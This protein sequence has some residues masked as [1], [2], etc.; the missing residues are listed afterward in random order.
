MNK[1]PYDFQAPYSRQT[2]ITGA[3]PCPVI[4][5][6]SGA[7]VA[8]AYDDKAATLFAAAPEL[9]ELLEYIA[10]HA[11]MASCNH[12]E[13]FMSTLEHRTASL[14]EISRRTKLAIAKAKGE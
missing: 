12:G 5:D 7:V 6:K 10:G 2:D 3:L 9:L 11:D 8:H 13:S 14:I 1:G 4:L